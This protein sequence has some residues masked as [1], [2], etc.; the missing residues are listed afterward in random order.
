LET[1]AIFDPDR[2]VVARA[3]RVSDRQEFPVRADEFVANEELG[4]H[5][6]DFRLTAPGRCD[7]HQ[8]V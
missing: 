1:K 8:E 2:H 7:H 3:F 4:T 5:R 6:Q